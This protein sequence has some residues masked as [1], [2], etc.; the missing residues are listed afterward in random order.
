MN[1]TSRITAGRSAE[2]EG[3]APLWRKLWDSAEV[4]F[5][6]L[7]SMIFLPKKIL[8]FSHIKYIVNHKPKNELPPG[9]DEGV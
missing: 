1:M 2:V 8:G 6:L 9:H 5:L 7:Q 3:E 4:C